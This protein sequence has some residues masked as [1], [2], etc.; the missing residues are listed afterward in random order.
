MGGNGGSSFVP[1]LPTEE[2]FAAP[3]RLIGEG[4]VTASK[5]L[6][7]FGHLVEGFSFEVSGGQIVDFKADRG[8]DVLA[9][10][11]ATDEGSVRFGE[12]A[13]VPMSSAVAAEGLIWN[14]T[15]YDENDGCHIAVGRSYPI[16]IEGGTEMSPEQLEASGMNISSTHVDFVVG[17]PDLNV[18]GITQKGSEEP[19]ILGGEWGFST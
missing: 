6:S 8:R 4:T 19:I 2:V 10:L 18:F 9:E 5:P 7:L 14:N 17:S 3:H 15:L 16:C 13:M 1:N 12:V 11:V